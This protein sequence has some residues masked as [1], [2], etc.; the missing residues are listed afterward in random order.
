[1][2]ASG[3]KDED[4]DSERIIASIE[5]IQSDENIERAQLKDLERM[6]DELKQKEEAYKKTWNELH[7]K[8]LSYNNKSKQR[9]RIRIKI[10]DIE[11]WKLNKDVTELQTSDVRLSNDL[12]KLGEECDLLASNLEII[13]EQLE[14]TKQALWQACYLEEKDPFK[15]LNQYLL[16]R[17]FDYNNSSYKP[18]SSVKDFRSEISLEVMKNILDDHPELKCDEKMLEFILSS[19]ATP[20]H[21]LC[22]I[23]DYLLK[24]DNIQPTLKTIEY[25]RSIHDQFTDLNAKF[26][27]EQLIQNLLSF[28]DP[29]VRKQFL[30]HNPKYNLPPQPNPSFFSPG[31]TLQDVQPTDT[32]AERKDRKGP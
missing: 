14:A 7:E 15:K 5:K 29:T 18:E 28:A 19:E 1:M 30:D 16:S 31:P 12:S 17:N 25:A 22:D 6:K 9:R 24:R 27:A 8:E 13:E 4:Q 32:P 3:K 26:L 21:K 10:R 23:I 11:Y 20:W 2:A